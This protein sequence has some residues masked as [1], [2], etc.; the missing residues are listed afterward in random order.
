[1]FHGLQHPGYLGADVA[2]PVPVNDAGDPAHMLA[3]FSYGRTSRYS[4]MSQS[5]TVAQKR[6]HS[7][8]L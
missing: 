2:S 5:E 3:P 7:S 6:S 1:V 4:A 8:V